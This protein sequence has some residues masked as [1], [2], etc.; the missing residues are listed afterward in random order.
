MIPLFGR[1]M[2]V[3][4]RSFVGTAC[5]KPRNRRGT[6]GRLWIGEVG[7]ALSRCSDRAASGGAN[8]L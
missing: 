4:S 7:P 5:G 2:R 8:R 3:W 1:V 6:V